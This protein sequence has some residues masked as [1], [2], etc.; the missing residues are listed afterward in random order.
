MAPALSEAAGRGRLSRQ[1]SPPGPADSS[2]RVMPLSAPAGPWPL[3]RASGKTPLA[4]CTAPAACPAGLARARPG[5]RSQGPCVRRSGHAAPPA[6]RPGPGGGAHDSLRVADSESEQRASCRR[7][8]ALRRRGVYVP[9]KILGDDH[10]LALARALQGRCH[11]LLLL[12]QSR[13]WLSSTPRHLTLELHELGNKRALAPG[14]P[15]QSCATPMRLS[16]ACGSAQ[17]SVYKCLAPKS[18][19][20]PMTSDRRA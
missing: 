11:R 7:A 6:A 16:G 5:P 3:V 4:A 14:N 20:E 12:T 8:I 10:M 9:I 19:A 17:R 1:V 2:F 13:G 18:F 15:S